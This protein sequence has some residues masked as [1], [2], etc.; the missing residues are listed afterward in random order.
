MPHC[1]ARARPAPDDALPH[2]WVLAA[3]V[4]HA[5]ATL[6]KELGVTAL[7]VAG[8]PS[9]PRGRAPP[10]HP[11]AVPGDQQPAGR[12]SPVPRFCGRAGGRPRP[13]ADAPLTAA[14][15]I[16]THPPLLTA[17][18]RAAAAAP[19]QP[20]RGAGTHRP[21]CRAPN[22]GHRT[23]A[24]PRRRTAAPPHLRT[25]APPRRRAAAPLLRRTA[26]PPHL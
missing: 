5:A 10:R 15:D 12:R 16:L 8:V 4:L 13:A 26:A 17:L 21:F 7:A 22:D 6:S 23:A 1:A 19:P 20:P 2:R 11:A 25:S 3:C 9:R 24:P 14:H 18:R